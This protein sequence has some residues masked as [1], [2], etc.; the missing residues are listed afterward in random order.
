VTIICLIPHPFCD[1]D[2]LLK[3]RVLPSN[4]S[5]QRLIDTSGP[6]AFLHGITQSTTQQDNR[7]SIE[8]NL[9][10]PIPLIRTRAFFLGEEIAE[11][12]TDK[13][14]MPSPVD[15]PGAHSWSKRGEKCGNNA[16][17]WPQVLR[18]HCYEP[19]T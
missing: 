16:A 7:F 1:I 18:R 6:K 17:C 15:Q 14:K 11:D 4:F 19:K 13:P 2:E 9:R 5:G 12:W 10:L 8:T 3:Q